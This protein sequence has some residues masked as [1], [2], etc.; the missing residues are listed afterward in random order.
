MSRA[1]GFLVLV[2]LLLGGIWV[3]EHTFTSVSLR[4][5]LLPVLATPLERAQRRAKDWAADHRMGGAGCYPAQTRGERHR[6]AA[7]PQ[8]ELVGWCLGTNWDDMRTPCVTTP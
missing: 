4:A 8:Q 5:D 2:A 6:C 1:T 7:G 3:Y